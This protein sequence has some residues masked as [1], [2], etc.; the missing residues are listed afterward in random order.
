M[1]P[2]DYVKLTVKDTGAGMTEEV[3][4][5]IFEPFFTTRKPGTGTGM[6]LAVVYGVVKAH[7]GA[8]TVKSAVGHGSTFEVF[9]PQAQREQPKQ[10]EAPLL[11]LPTGTERILFVDDEEWLAETAQRMLEHLGY[12]VT[13]ARHGSEAWNLF[14]QDPWRFDLVITDQAMPGITGMTLAQKML[15]VREEMSII[16]CTGYSET[17]SAEKARG[18]GIRA[19]AMK[20][21]VTRELADIVR[22]VLDGRRTAA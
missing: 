15:V 7:G 8:V 21:L 16:L 5:R 18:A 10:E 1:E 22:R 20:P 11:D 3:R 17:V 13:V 6:G 2:G 9:L 19:F 14:L 4:K 12:R